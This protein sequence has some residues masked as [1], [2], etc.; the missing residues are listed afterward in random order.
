MFQKTNQSIQQIFVLVD[1]QKTRN[2][3]L[4]NSN[5]NQE[6]TQGQQ[7]NYYQKLLYTAN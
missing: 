4:M 5:Y 2:L 7:D 3:S 6:L 1:K